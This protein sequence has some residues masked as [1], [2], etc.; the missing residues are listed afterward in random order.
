MNEHFLGPSRP[1]VDWDLLETGPGGQRRA[2]GSYT[3]DVP[4]DQTA[5]GPATLFREPR[6][7]EL[8]TWQTD[9]DHCHPQGQGPFFHP[10]PTQT[11]NYHKLSDR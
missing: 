1:G 7:P 2:D 3:R 6:A 11:Q 10:T 8:P 4:Q 5:Q 9:Q